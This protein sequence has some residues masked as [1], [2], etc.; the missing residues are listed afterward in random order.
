MSR[1]ALQAL[2][3]VAGAV[4]AALASRANAQ[5]HLHKLRTADYSVSG[6]VLHQAERDADETLEHVMSSAK[7][8]AFIVSRFSSADCYAVIDEDIQEQD[9]MDEQEALANPDYHMPDDFDYEEELDYDEQYRTEEARF[10]QTGSYDPPEMEEAEP[11]PTQEEMDE[12]Y[13]AQESEA[14]PHESDHLPADFDNLSEE[15]QTAAMIHAQEVF[16]A[17]QHVESIFTDVTDDHWAM[18]NMYILQLLEFKRIPGRHKLPHRLSIPTD[19]SDDCAMWMSNSL[20]GW[21]VCIYDDNNE[22]PEVQDYFNKF[23]VRQ[24]KGEQKLHFGNCSDFFRWLRDLK[25][26]ERPWWSKIY[27]DFRWYES[28]DE[29]HGSYNRSQ[30]RTNAWFMGEKWSA[31][32]SESQL[33]A[34]R[35]KLERYSK[36]GLLIEVKQPTLRVFLQTATHAVT[37][38]E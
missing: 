18:C 12:F 4:S 25:S 36:D 28:C 14:P 23:E 31:C 6:N 38:D 13:A 20:T 15:E 11:E 7:Q 29:E 2:H 19:P 10:E 33:K 21:E 3:D 9:E 27:T 22:Y 34:G 24:L 30:F 26:T 16:A 37:S 8:L 1:K 35:V 5:Q 17:Q 32:I